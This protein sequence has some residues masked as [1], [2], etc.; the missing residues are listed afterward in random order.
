MINRGSLTSPHVTVAS[1]S[2]LQQFTRFWMQNGHCTEIANMSRLT[3]SIQLLCVD[4]AMQH[5]QSAAIP[6]HG[7]IS[8]ETIFGVGCRHEVPNRIVRVADKSE[9]I[10]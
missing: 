7:L 1:I 4:G 2:I 6:T 3:Y 10:I 5:E 8:D 9:T